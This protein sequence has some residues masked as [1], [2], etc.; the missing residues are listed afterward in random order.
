MLIIS[1]MATFSVFKGMMILYI[2]TTNDDT[3]NKQPKLAWHIKFEK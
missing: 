2:E 3:L 1:S